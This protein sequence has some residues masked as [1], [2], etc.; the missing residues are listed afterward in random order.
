MKRASCQSVSAVAIVAL[1][2]ALLS[3]QSVGRQP[4]SGLV[5]T[6][7]VS[8][9]LKDQDL[10]LLQV[11]EKKDYDAAHLPGAQF[12]PREVFGVR[13]QAAN[14][15]LQVPPANTL[16]AAL[17]ALGVSDSSRVVLYFGTDW[18]TPTARAYVTLDYLGLGDNTFIMDGGLPA[19]QAERRAVTTEVASPRVGR[20]TAHPRPEVVADLAYVQ[21]HLQDAG[22]IIID[23]RTPEFFAGEKPGSMPRAGRI[24]GAR[25]VP[26]SS[27]VTDDNKLKDPASLRAL[28]AAQGVTAGKSVITYCH[29][30]QQASLDYF[31]AKSL[32]FPVRLYDGSFEEWSRHAALPVATGPER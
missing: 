24:P 32:G 17:A 25:N 3:A 5:T 1:S 4:R 16:V 6:E 18:V 22:T 21:A 23:S 10:V 11:G 7:W 9:H 2:A 19:W 8:Q 14:L 31:V 29:I 27:L 13:D 20:L 30:G 12:L 15:T 26:F 28:L